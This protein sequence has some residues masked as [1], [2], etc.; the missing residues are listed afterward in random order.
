MQAPQHSAFTLPQFLERIELGEYQIPQFQRKFVWTLD[1]A[2]ALIDSILKG[3]PI[4]TFILWDATELFIDD[5]I[6][7]PA[8]L[9]IHSL[10]DLKAKLIS[11]VVTLLGV[12]LLGYAVSWTGAAIC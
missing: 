5:T 4:G 12:L 10:D 7:L 9:Q 1:Q 8:W 2:A 6:P 11:V 3:Y